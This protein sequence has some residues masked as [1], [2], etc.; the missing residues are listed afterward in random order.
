M[1]YH[2]R[3]K[4]VPNLG[5]GPEYQL[6]KHLLEPDTEFTVQGEGRFKFRYYWPGDGSIACY[7]PYKQDGTP[8]GDA[9]GRYFKP[10]KI[11]TVH[12]KRKIR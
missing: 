3:V 2:R 4:R 5:H 9:K 10:E 6:G 12:R 11:T 7:G 8:K 1:P